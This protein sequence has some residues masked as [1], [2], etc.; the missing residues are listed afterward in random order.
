[1]A[2]GK[3]IGEASLEAPHGGESRARGKSKLVTQTIRDPC[4]SS[5]FIYHRGRKVEIRLPG[6][7]HIVIIGRRGLSGHRQ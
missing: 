6:T 2:T 4:G 5:D 1:M 7:K 3:E